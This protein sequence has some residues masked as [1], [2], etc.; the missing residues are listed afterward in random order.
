MEY[1]IDI[2]HWN[3]VVK[4]DIIDKP[5]F[6]FIKATDG[7]NRIDPQFINNWNGA[8][9]RNIPRGAYHFFHPEKDASIQAQLFSKT[10][11]VLSRS[12]LDPVLDI[13]VTTTNYLAILEGIKTWLS[14]VESMLNRRP[15][16]YTNPSFWV[17]TMKNT[18]EFSDHLLWTAQYNNNKAPKLYGGWESYKYWQF[19]SRG[20]IKGIKGFVDLN[21]V[22]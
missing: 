6:V 9:S 15:I 7:V 21:K 1:G 14:V 10:V 12:D 18:S 16:I 20:S 5:K 4:W 22:K 3:G 13:E 17:S 19:S 8:L 11:G 2:S